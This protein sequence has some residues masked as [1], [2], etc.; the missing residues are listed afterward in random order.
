MRMLRRAFVTLIVIAV[1]TAGAAWFLA[2]REAGPVIEVK[3][4]AG[5]EQR[6]AAAYEKERAKRERPHEME[7]A[8]AESARETRRC[9]IESAQAALGKAKREHEEIVAE[10]EKDLAAVQ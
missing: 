7:E 1:G 6:T 3:S 4:P 8:A 9:H 5:A 2:G 10:I